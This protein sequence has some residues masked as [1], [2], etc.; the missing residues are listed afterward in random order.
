MQDNLLSDLQLG[1][2]EFFDARTKTKTVYTSE[3]QRKLDLLYQEL[4]KGIEFTPDNIAKLINYN[5]TDAGNAELFRDI[6]GEN[7]RY[8]PELGKWLKF[9]GVRWIEASEETKLQMLAVIRRRIDA[10]NELLK[11][12]NDELRA[13]IIKWSLASESDSR[14]KSALAIAQCMLYK[15]F[16]EFDKDRFLLCVANGAIDLKLDSDG[17]R[18]AKPEDHLYKRSHVKYDLYADCPRW[19]QF[20]D[21]IFL[22]N[23]ELIAFIQKAVGY[24]LTG[25]ISAQC[26]FILYGTGAN[27]KSVFL[28]ILQSLMGDFAITTSMDTF[29][30]RKFKGNPQIP[31]DL[32][33]LY[34]KRFVKA[35]ELKEN[36]RIDEERIKALT[37]EEEIQARY[38]YHEPFNFMPEFKIWLGVN[39]K[40]VIRGTD[41]AIWRRP[42]LIPFEAYFPPENRDENLLDT[43]KTELP[44]ILLWAVEGCHKWQREG[45]DFPEKVIK[46]TNGYR[47]ESDIVGRFLGECTVHGNGC[48]VKAKELYEAYKKWCEDSGEYAINQKNFGMKLTEKG[49]EKKRSNSD[50]SYCY[51]TIGLLDN[52]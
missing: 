48:K 42:K 8:V 3:E 30:D 22:G 16:T 2:I 10:A 32:A 4:T 6:V 27:G 9:N 23:K 24:T 20:L 11:A 49:Y 12:Q 33:A 41:E 37:G 38:L 44:G 43:L 35:S 18:K 45:L 19:L 17:F 14:L 1:T 50:G 26:F 13:K 5:C 46:A 36:T 25:S 47:E 40:P 39:H 52:Y 21:E 34:G 7:Y 29:K 31:N 51:T 15:H 28:T